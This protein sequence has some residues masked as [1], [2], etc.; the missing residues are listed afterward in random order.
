MIVVVPTS[1]ALI[2]GAIG[3]VIWMAE[4][5]GKARK[6][7]AAREAK[8]RL[9][10][11]LAAPQPS[12]QLPYGLSSQPD[13]DADRLGPGPP[14]RPRTQCGSGV[15]Q[16]RALDLQLLGFRVRAGQAGGDGSVDIPVRPF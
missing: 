13:N 14:K 10:E 15:D 5:P 8:A 4:Q 2:I 7:R 9:R 6:R 16:A 1:V 12:T 11:D 3:L